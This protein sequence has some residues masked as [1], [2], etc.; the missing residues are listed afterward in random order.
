[1]SG[2]QGDEHKKK[3]FQ[4]ENILACISIEYFIHYRVRV[5]DIIDVHGKISDIGNSGVILPGVLYNDVSENK[6]AP[7][8]I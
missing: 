7:Q 4:D 3:V 5:M 6:H 1:M 2:P 8:E